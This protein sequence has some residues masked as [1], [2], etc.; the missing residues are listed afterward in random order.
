MNNSIIEGLT[1]LE[2]TLFWGLI[3]KILAQKLLPETS[4]NSTE[5]QLQL[6]FKVDENGSIDVDSIQLQL[7]QIQPI[8]LFEKS[9]TSTEKQLQSKLN[10]EEDENTSTEIN[11]MKAELEQLQLELN[12]KEDENSSTKVDSIN[13]KLEQSKPLFSI[14][15]FFS[16]ISFAALALGFVVTPV[17]IILILINSGKI[18]LVFIG[19][20][21]SVMLGVGLF[22][23]KTNWGIIISSFI[24]LVILLLLA[25]WQ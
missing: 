8:S 7:V 18:I 14:R 10:I 20:I 17:I 16:I 15:S 1:K 6:N 13:A 4:F 12:I 19:S 21:T 11:S 24:V 2:E 9:S 5:K 22:N 23:G 25:T 3:N